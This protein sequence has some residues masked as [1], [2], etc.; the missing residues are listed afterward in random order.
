LPRYDHKVGTV[1]FSV[2]CFAQ[3]A[4]SVAPER[5]PAAVQTPLN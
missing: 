3:T 4:A 2:L 1:W 5:L